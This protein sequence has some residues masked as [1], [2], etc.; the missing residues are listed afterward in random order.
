VLSVDAHAQLRT[1]LD[2]F[3][4]AALALVAPARVRDGV[5]RAEQLPEDEVRWLAWDVRI[6][7]GML[8]GGRG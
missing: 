3:T 1:A 7:A 5:N 2:E 8:S 6:L 4:A